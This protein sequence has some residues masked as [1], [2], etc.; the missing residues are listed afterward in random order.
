MNIF[1]IKSG[2][3][4]ANKDHHTAPTGLIKARRF[5]DDDY[6]EEIE[7]ASDS[8]HFFFKGKCCHSFRKT[9]P[10]HNLKICLCI[11]TREVK[12]AC[13]S[14]VAGKVGFCN[15]VLAFM[16]K[17]CKFT[18]YN[19]TSVKEL[20]EEQD[21][22]SSLACTSQFSNGTRK[23]GERTLHHSQLLKLKSIK[24]RSTNPDHDLVLNFSAQVQ[25][26]MAV[27]GARWCDFIVYTSR[28]LYV[29]RITFDPV[30]WAELNQKL[31]SNYFNH[32]IKFAFAKLCQVNCQVNNS[33]D[34][35]VNCTSTTV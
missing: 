27:T 9:E 16:F 24:Q 13:F 3:A 21:Q 2:K 18:L 35:Q 31:V 11:V 34:C 7:C 17:M 4:I 28:G 33:N 10:P 6:L 12:S 22:Q 5:L 19:C 1:V 15:H 8:K 30:F 14:C 25:G 32:F 26:Q 29:Q 23:V 20:S